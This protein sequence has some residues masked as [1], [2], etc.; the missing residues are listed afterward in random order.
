MNNSFITFLQQF[1]TQ[2]PLLL[3]CLVGIFVAC[4]FWSKYSQAALLVV[5]GCG[6]MLG[7][8]LIFAILHRVLI[9]NVR[10]GN[11]DLTVIFQVMSLVRSVLNALAVGL[12][13]SA[14]FVGRKPSNPPTFY[15]PNKPV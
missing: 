6:I 7:V 10:V 13:I 3:T 1:A 8:P 5:L 9:Q 15:P 4:S 2:A 14:A 11:G 12:F